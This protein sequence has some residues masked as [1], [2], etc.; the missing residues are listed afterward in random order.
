MAH[1]YFT[2]DCSIT[3]QPV[4]LRKTREPAGNFLICI[5]LILIT[6]AIVHTHSDNIAG[7][8]S[9]VINGVAITMGRV[10]KIVGV[11]IIH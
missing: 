3:M 10:S 8:C 6:Y 9:Q 5:L 2:D 1:P 4:M 7:I 11:A